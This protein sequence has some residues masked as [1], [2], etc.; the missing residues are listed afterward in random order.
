[1]DTS[2]V[3]RVALRTLGAEGREY[4]V[5]STD[6]NERPTKATLPRP[7]RAEVSATVRGSRLR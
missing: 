7:P 5:R 3:V 2:E 6:C 1:M 4:E